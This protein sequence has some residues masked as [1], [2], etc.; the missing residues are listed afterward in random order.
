MK[1][2]GAMT[3]I[4]TPMDGDNVDYPCLHQLVER[5]ISAGIDGIVAVGT[6]G[7]SA[8]LTVAEHVA[9]IQKSIEAAAG[10]VPVIAGAGANATHEAISLSR[11]SEEAGAEALLHVVPYYN[12]PTQEGLYQ[13]FRAIAA[14]TKLPIILYNVPGRTACDLLPPTIAR[15]AEL[16]TIVSIKDATADLR[17]ASDTL[18]LCGDKI[19]V[20]S[21]DDFTAFP[22]FAV[23]GH[24]V[25]SVVSNIVPDRVADMWDAAQ[26]GQWDKARGLHDSMLE[27]VDLL[28]C[29]SNPIPIKQAMALAGLMKPDVRLP[30]VPCSSEL[31][32]KLKAI[33]Q[34][35]NII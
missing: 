11:A 32:A 27:L 18:R 10:R 15:L 6:T 14:S 26:A 34:K 7:E 19:T 3:A 25:I 16:P 30:M 2:I 22:L 4:V 20:L 33:L 12:K 1:I 21:G 23:G 35:E 24:G 31:T 28:F 17:R 13:H 8:T 9:V 5:Q 29:E